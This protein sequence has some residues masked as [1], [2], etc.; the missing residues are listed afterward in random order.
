MQKI[1]VLE[2]LWFV[3]TK[4]FR[5]ILIIFA[6][7]ALN[8]C[9]SQPEKSMPRTGSTNSEIYAEPKIDSIDINLELSKNDF[10]IFHQSFPYTSS[11]Q[12]KIKDFYFVRVH[13]QTPVALNLESNTS[14]DKIKNPRFYGYGLQHKRN[15]TIIPIYGELTGVTQVRGVSGLLDEKVSY[16]GY[17]GFKQHFKWFRDKGSSS[18]DL[19]RKLSLASFAGER[20]ISRRTDFVFSS[21]VLSKSCIRKGKN[22]VQNP[23]DLVSFHLVPGVEASLGSKQWFVYTNL[24]KPVNLNFDFPSQSIFNN[25]VKSSNELP[26]IF[27]NFTDNNYIKCYSLGDLQVKN[28]LGKQEHKYS[29]FYPLLNQFGRFSNFG[30]SKY[31]KFNFSLD[32]DSVNYQRLITDY[33][34]ASQFLLFSRQLIIDSAGNTIAVPTVKMSVSGY[35]NM[36]YAKDTAGNLEVWDIGLQSAGFDHNESFFG[37]KILT[38][39]PI[40]ISTLDKLHQNGWS[41]LCENGHKIMIGTCE[42]STYPQVIFFN[43]KTEQI[44]ISYSPSERHIY[45]W[46][47]DRRTYDI[48][49]LPPL[50]ASGQSDEEVRA[51]LMCEQLE[52]NLAAIDQRLD[53]P[54]LNENPF[55]KWFEQD[56]PRLMSY[57][58]KGER[59][60]TPA[61]EIAMKAIKHERRGIDQ[62]WSLLN[63]TK[64][65]HSLADD[66]YCPETK[67]LANDY[68]SYTQELY[69]QLNSSLSKM[70]SEIERQGWEIYRATKEAHEARLKAQTAE[71]NRQLWASTLSS[72]RNTID[73]SK[74]VNEI[75]ASTRSLA[76]QGRQLQYRYHKHRAQPKKNT[77]SG[78]PIKNVSTHGIVTNDS[79]STVDNKPVTQSQPSNSSASNN[80]I[81]KTPEQISI[82]PAVNSQSTS[83]HSDYGNAPRAPSSN[84]SVQSNQTISGASS[85][86][87]TQNEQPRLPKF[88]YVKEVKAEHTGYAFSSEAQALKGIQETWALNALN[89]YCQDKYP[90]SSGQD[91]VKKVSAIKVVRATDSNWH[92]WGL[93]EGY[94]RILPHHA[95]Y[96]KIRNCP[97]ERPG[98]PN[99]AVR[100]RY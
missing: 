34:Y 79:T 65:A 42:G 12:T 82:S 93:V 62:L 23:S 39:L 54:F 77:D 63:Q 44:E 49:N 20:T 58:R 28:R 38:R 57:I 51:T 53:K 56:V 81:S 33:R 43:G 15:K 11:L 64:R 16:R 98:Q 74:I 26:S 36:L 72:I 24:P 13:R 50:F 22:K 9:A 89:T 75:S 46:N 85:T 78:K 31:P 41:E 8:A 1:K 60:P 32:N 35:K 18:D 68:R 48:R 86:N 5:F 2:K 4:E 52:E 21:Q 30:T 69:D 99:C 97:S 84:D 14:L 10:V 76:H 87:K 70:S 47:A 67:N 66:K 73:I 90:Q 25:L 7:F 29:V 100:E 83:I 71:Y 95:L 27:F 3:Q 88:V 45:S 37:E 96:E 91:G 59:A 92:A 6:I 19:T 94:C 61:Y 40:T 80:K 55:A 17:F